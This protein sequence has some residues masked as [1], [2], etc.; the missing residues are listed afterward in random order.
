MKI[1]AIIQ[2][3]MGS[4]RL[5]GKTLLPILG[6]PLLERLIE[7]LRFVERIDQI[8]VATTV[9]PDDDA[10]EA[11]CDRLGAG[12]YRGSVDD[13]LDRVLEAA[14]TYHAD[15]IVE[16]CG[17]CPLIDPGTVRS[18][19]ELYDT[20]AFDHTSNILCEGYP[21]GLDTQVYATRVLAEVAEL[22]QNPADREHVSLYI[23]EHPKRY[24]LGRYE[25]PA[26]IRR[27]RLRLTV[28]TPDDLAL[29]QAIYE[30]LYPSKP[31]F[32]IQDVVR[33][34]D[35]HPELADYNAYVTQKPVR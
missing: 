34:L 14:R 22:T 3:R 8:V 25:T 17:D 7:R 16:I 15:L 20:G 18:V 31:D 24:R 35:D 33:L 26:D 6:R 30:H 13:V 11:T 9:A 5:P 27:R 10:I 12:C 23:Y 29:I 1:V 28:D 2:A 19:I 21:R 4:T 32:S